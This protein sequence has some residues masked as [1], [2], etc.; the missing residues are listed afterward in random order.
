M[1]NTAI[2]YPNLNIPDF[3]LAYLIKIDLNQNKKEIR[4]RSANVIRLTPINARQPHGNQNHTRLALHFLQLI[5]FA[6]DYCQNQSLWTINSFVFLW[7]AFSEGHH[8]D[9]STS[10]QIYFIWKYE[11]RFAVI[12][13]FFP[14]RIYMK[15][16]FK[17][18]CDTARDSALREDFNDPSWDRYA[19]SFLFNTDGVTTISSNLNV[20]ELQILSKFL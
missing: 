18:W 15:I 14:F 17:Q 16:K 20:N 19:N 6:K 4:L 7:I 3:Y 5:S 1:C 2:N 11:L 13:H 9:S 12:N 10:F 8:L